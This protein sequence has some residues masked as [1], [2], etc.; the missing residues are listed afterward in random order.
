MP[1]AIQTFDQ[2]VEELVDRIGGRNDIDLRMRDWVNQAQAHFAR[3]AIEAPLLEGIKT[4]PTIAGQTEYDYTTEVNWGLTELIG[5][6]LMRNT[7]K[8]WLMHRMSWE[9]YRRLSTQ[10]NSSPVRYARNGHL[11]ALDPVPTAVE[12]LKID[13]RKMPQDGVLAFDTSW[14]EW[15]IRYAAYIA[16]GAVQ[17]YDQ[18]KAVFTS[19]P[20]WLQVRLQS[21]LA[22]AE[23][24][25]M[26]DNEAGMVPDRT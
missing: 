6:R 15:L 12:Q 25:A 9:E 26:W 24:E 2:C 19:L 23:W 16:W 5:I 1:V 10:S 17:E 11:I 22:E 13:Y 14:T 7:T 21:P 18:A 8:A 3:C 4:V 20:M